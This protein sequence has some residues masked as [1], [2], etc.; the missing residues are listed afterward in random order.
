MH[1]EEVKLLA[2]QAGAML[3]HTWGGPTEASGLD[4]FKFADKI[5]AFVRM[6][7]AY[8][9]DE[10]GSDAEWHTIIDTI[11]MGGIE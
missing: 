5:E 2:T 9:V 6:S 1:D 3:V 11:R 7:V 10:L 8:D 4:I